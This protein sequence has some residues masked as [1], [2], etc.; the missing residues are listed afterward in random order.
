MQSLHA[1]SIVIAIDNE[2]DHTCISLPCNHVH[3]PDGHSCS[4]ET[5]S[6]SCG[7]CSCCYVTLVTG[8]TDEVRRPASF[9]KLTGIAEYWNAGALRKAAV[10]YTPLNDW[11]SCMA[12]LYFSI[13]QSTADLVTCHA[14]RIHMNAHTYS[15]TRRPPGE[16]VWIRST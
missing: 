8:C 10:N 4:P 2:K 11:A 15:N 16:T 14:I 12:P 7:T 3:M 1:Q 5:C 13:P 9:H 6:I